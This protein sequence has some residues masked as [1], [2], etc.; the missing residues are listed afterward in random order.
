MDREAQVNGAMPMAGDQRGIQCQCEAARNTHNQPGHDRL[1]AHPTRARRHV[2]GCV[3]SPAQ[4]C[5]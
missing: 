1:T 3:A 2:C 4:L 5:A